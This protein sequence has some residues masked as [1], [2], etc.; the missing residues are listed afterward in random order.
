MYITPEQKIELENH[1]KA[2]GVH[3]TVICALAL[4]DYLK[5]RKMA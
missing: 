2:T 3:M 1:S 4:S 5:D